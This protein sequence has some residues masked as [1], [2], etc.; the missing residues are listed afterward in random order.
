MSTANHS[1]SWPVHRLKPTGLPPDRV[2][3]WCMN[4]NMPMGMEN[5]LCAAGARPSPPH[6]RT[7]GGG[8]LGR[9]LGRQQHA[10]AAGLGAPARHQLDQL[11]LRIT[12]IGLEIGRSEAAVVVATEAA[13][14]GLPA[15]VGA[16]WAVVRTDRAFAGIAPE[17]PRLVPVKLG[18]KRQRVRLA[19][20]ARANPRA[21]L[22]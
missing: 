14:A 15:Q 2:R 4:G 8:D 19:L 10:A 13:R 17:A 12:G 9:H 5:A 1:Q 18:A 20:A 22:A 7:A 16:V 3:K 21:L 11:D 6:Q